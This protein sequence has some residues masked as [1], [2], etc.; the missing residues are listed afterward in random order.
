MKYTAIVYLIFAITASLS[1][2]ATEQAPDRLVINGDTMLLH[3]LPL[4]QWKKQNDWE[5]LLFSDSLR[6]VSTGC[7]RGYIAYWEVIDNR[8]YLTNIYNEDS[9][10]KLSLDTLFV[11]KVYDGRVYADWFSDT[12][13]A[14]QGK[15]LYSMH[16][17]FSSIHEDEFEYVFEKGVLINSAS[18][19]NSL[20]RNTFQIMNEVKLTSIID[21]LID[22]TTLPPIEENIRVTLLVEADKQGR[23]DSVLTMRGHSDIFNDEA[24]RVAHLLTQ[25]PVIYKRGEFLRQPFVLHFIFTR[26]K[27]QQ[28]L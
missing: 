12:V 28:V 20:S 14:Y 5:G 24:L 8:L 13:T 17:G 9:S 6:S 15:L 27:Q 10:A 22:W 19:D 11:G 1:T 16:M 21:S 25:L 18:F 2:Y 7:W 26:K 3:A 23:V 4:E